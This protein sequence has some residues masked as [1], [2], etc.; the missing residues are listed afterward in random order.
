[1]NNNYAVK[2]VLFK[3]RFIWSNNGLTFNLF[4]IRQFIIETYFVACTVINN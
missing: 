2:F 4:I 1:M 3:I